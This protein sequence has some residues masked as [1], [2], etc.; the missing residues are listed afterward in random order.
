ME[1]NPSIVFTSLNYIRQ[2]RLKFSETLSNDS[3][4]LT[5]QIE[6]LFCH[7]NGARRQRC[8]FLPT[9]ENLLLKLIVGTV[10][11]QRNEAFSCDK[12]KNLS[13]AKLNNLNVSSNHHVI[14]FVV[15]LWS[16][17]VSYAS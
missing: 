7:R 6:I 16:S 11:A 2:S 9:F 3:L 4:N 15:P 1:F 12:R 14:I 10:L 17:N 13:L 8:H 5:N